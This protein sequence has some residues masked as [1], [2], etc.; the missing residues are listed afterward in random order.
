MVSPPKR[1]T[2]TKLC[3]GTASTSDAKAENCFKCHLLV[4]QFTYTNRIPARLSEKPNQ[5]HQEEYDVDYEN[6]DSIDKGPVCVQ[7][8]AGIRE[9]GVRHSDNCQVFVRAGAEP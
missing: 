1:L 6:A 2:P 5:H 7:D 8:C 9:R 3:T 4:K